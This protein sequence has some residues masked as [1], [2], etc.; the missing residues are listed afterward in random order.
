MIDR[1]HKPSVARAKRRSAPVFRMSNSMLSNVKVGK[2]T[3]VADRRPG[4]TCLFHRVTLV[5]ETWSTTRED[6]NQ[7]RYDG[8]ADK[9]W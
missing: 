8:R 2:G 6:S 5:A 3:I 1:Q 4:N 9:D 7:I